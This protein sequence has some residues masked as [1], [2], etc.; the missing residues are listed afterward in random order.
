GHGC[1]HRRPGRLPVR[2]TGPARRRHGRR[3]SGIGTAAE[4]RGEE[5]MKIGAIGFAASEPKTG[6]AVVSIDDRLNELI[7]DAKT[8]SKVRNSDSGVPRSAGEAFESHCFSL[9]CADAFRCGSLYVQRT[10]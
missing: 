4:P 2:K 8:S 3:A 6:K 10:R 7:R 1:L 5:E 9:R